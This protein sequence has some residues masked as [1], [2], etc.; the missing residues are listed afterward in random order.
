MRFCLSC[1]TQNILQVKLPIPDETSFLDRLLLWSVSGA[2]NTAEGEAAVH[3][4]AAVVNK[5]A[6]SAS[7]SFLRQS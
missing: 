3:L 4:L 1:V 5:R 2:E 7:D 6:D